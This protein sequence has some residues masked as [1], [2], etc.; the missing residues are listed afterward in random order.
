[1]KQ[2]TA[3]AAWLRTTWPAQALWNAV[4]AVSGAVVVF[5]FVTLVA[6]FL[7]GQI[8]VW[9]VGIAFWPYVLV[10]SKIT[11]DILRAGTGAFFMCA[12]TIGVLLSGLPAVFLGRW[13]LLGIALPLL[14]LAMLS[15][16]YLLSVLPN[17]PSLTVAI[18]LS[19]GVVSA[20]FLNAL[21]SP[22]WPLL[23]A[24][25][26]IWYAIAVTPIGRESML[27]VPKNNQDYSG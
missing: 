22:P 14:A 7:P 15:S 9:A 21:I 16:A 11:G 27:H 17:R 19:C 5:Q 25:I 3:W 4:L 12:G 2:V 18:G 13:G 24:I 6:P 20:A 23:L 26:G 10:L 8:S 1:M